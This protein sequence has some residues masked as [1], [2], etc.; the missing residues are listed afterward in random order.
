MKKCSTDSL[1]VSEIVL[2]VSIK[3]KIPTHVDIIGIIRL[4][5]CFQFD[6]K[7]R[8][9]C[10][11]HI[12][13]Y[14]DIERL[15]FY[16]IITSFHSYVFVHWL[17]QCHFVC[18]YLYIVISQLFTASR[19]FNKCIYLS[20]NILYGFKV[21]MTLISIFYVRT[22]ENEMYMYIYT[23]NKE[24]RNRVLHGKFCML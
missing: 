22:H 8:A 23:R 5:I 19:L 9:D 4:Y 11:W 16:S 24:T 3:L 2:N 20:D 1:L 15:N 21:Y 13:S 18:I 12:F 6:L 7:Y 10:L 17:Y 14:L